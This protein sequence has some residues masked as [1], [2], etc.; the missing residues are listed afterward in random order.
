MLFRSPV[1]W[2]TFPGV[3]VTPLLFNGVLAF[4]GGYSLAYALLGVP[5]LAIGAHLLLRRAG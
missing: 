3:M 1:A 5:G 2:L 4:G